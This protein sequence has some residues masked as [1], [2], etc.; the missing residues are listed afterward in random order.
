[1][2]VFEAGLGT[3]LAV[4]RGDVDLVDQLAQDWLSLLERSSRNE[5]F[6]GPE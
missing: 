5:P 3:T 4:M 2:K 1:M 6:Y